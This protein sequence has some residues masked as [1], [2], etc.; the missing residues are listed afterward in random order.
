MAIEP[1]TT[2]KTGEIPV[3]AIVAVDV[4]GTRIAVANVG[5]NYYAF[6]DAC[7]HEQCSLAE[8]GE[9]A[10]TTVTCTCHG[11]EF[12]VRTGTMM[13]TERHERHLTTPTRLKLAIAELLVRVRGEYREMPGL[14]LTDVQAQRLWGLDDRTCALVL[15]ALV[16]Q[17][18]LRRTAAGT[19][20]RM[21]D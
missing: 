17:Q 6:D 21:S 14:K 12:D 3:G 8:M 15:A 1:V 2:I 7:T 10:G 19:Y 18:F 20:L 16:K 13:L 9:L 11:S 5:G 4:R